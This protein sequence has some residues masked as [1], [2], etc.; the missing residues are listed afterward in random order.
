M[1][2]KNVIIIVLSIII[3]I[4]LG[5]CLF[6]FFSKGNKN[7]IGGNTTENETN[8]SSSSGNDIE[9]NS[10]RVELTKSGEGWEVEGHPAAQYDGLFYNN[11]NE[12]ITDWE[13]II[14]VPSGS[15]IDSSWN[16]NYKMS[17]SKISITCVDYN[18]TIRANESIPFGMILVTPGDFDPSTAKVTIKI[19]GKE[20]KNG[21]DTSVATSTEAT[22]EEAT[23]EKSTEDNGTGKGTPLEE[24]GKLSVKGTDI[25]DANGNKFQ[26]K[27][28][29][30][31]GIG[32]FPEYV[33]KD[34]FMTLRDDW[35]ANVVRIAMY[36][37]EYNGYCSGGNKEEL[38]SLLCTGVD[39]ATELGMYA[40]I[41]WHI[42][43]DNDPNINKSEALVFFD[44]MSKKYANNDN[45]IYEICNE[46]NGN[47]SWSAVKSYAM[48]VIPVIR[49]NDSD[50]II[51][52]GT[53][54]WSQDV[55][56][57]ANDPITG[58]DNIMYA[59]HFYAA[60]HKDDIRNKVKTALDKG[61]PVF[62]SEYSICDAA[63]SGNIDYDQAQAWMDLINDKNLSYV[64]WSLSNKD[65]TSAMI[66][67]SCTKTSGWSDDD[68]SETGKWLKKN[69]K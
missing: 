39:E 59:V 41:D 69:L 23:T 4:L 37:A 6:L 9:E 56:I 50:A 55:D 51:I 42:L 18:E 2:K 10:F 67:P 24:H 57:A 43:N 15:K 31:H 16:G 64:Q 12:N 36:T 26:L 34:A 40:I 65:E 13:L 68:L 44:E 46:P 45:I 54:T 7:D 63:G 35:G 5:L 3:A 60:T 8:Q 53:P 58:Y 19:G 48:E 49:E 28:A 38:K 66:S 61:I 62:I 14:E 17:G 32:W 21:S 30:T 20:Y 29:S 27:G 47:T 52:V 22:T 1:N 33:N 11:T 25:V